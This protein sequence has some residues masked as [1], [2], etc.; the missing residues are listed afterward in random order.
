MHIC[1]YFT[2][3]CNMFIVTKVFVYYLY[4]CIWTYVNMCT[5]GCKE[6]RCKNVASICAYAHMRICGYRGAKRES[7]N[8]C[9]CSCTQF[10]IFPLLVDPGEFDVLFWFMFV[11]ENCLVWDA[12]KSTCVGFW[13]EGL[14][15]NF[16]PKCEQ[17]VEW[18]F[19]S[20]LCVKIQI[21]LI[22]VQI[23]PGNFSSKHETKERVKSSPVH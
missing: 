18:S 6:R 15:Q 20:R 12:L 11:W 1:A 16:I 10:C 4:L 23:I 21:T 8:C 2:P 5:W 13:C 17:A 3:I 14:T 7:E 22:C 19:G 9:T